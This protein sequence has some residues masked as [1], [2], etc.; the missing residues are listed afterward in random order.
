MKKAELLLILVLVVGIATVKL[1]KVEA[2]TAVTLVQEGTRCE[3]EC[4]YRWSY[5]WMNGLP[6]PYRYLYCFDPCEQQ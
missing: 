5:F 3:T 2:A 4:E 6:I 1:N